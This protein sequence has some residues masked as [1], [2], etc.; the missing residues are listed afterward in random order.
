MRNNLSDRSLTGLGLILCV[1]RADK[2]G[3]IILSFG[4]Y[5]FS[6]SICVIHL[7]QY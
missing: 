5:A 6:Y 1:E 7:D 4:I 2:L 3:E